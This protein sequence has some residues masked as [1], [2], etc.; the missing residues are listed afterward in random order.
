MSARCRRNC[1]GRIRCLRSDERILKILGG[2]VLRV[3]AEVEDW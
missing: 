2:N 3:L 1:A